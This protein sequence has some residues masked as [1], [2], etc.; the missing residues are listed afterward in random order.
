VSL[1][2][3]APA[4]RPSRFRSAAPR[5]AAAT[6]GRRLGLVLG[7]A[8][9]EILDHALRPLDPAGWDRKEM[10]GRVD[11][12]PRVGQT[13]TGA[14][15]RSAPSPVSWHLPLAGILAGDPSLGQGGRQALE[16]IDRQVQR[17]DVIEGERDR[18]LEVDPDPAV[19]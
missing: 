19:R 6:S 17:G 9:D 13:E 4:P 8:Q 18:L 1:K 11:D 12:H 7:G 16:V 2:A 3:S 5:P 10:E 15:A 14:R